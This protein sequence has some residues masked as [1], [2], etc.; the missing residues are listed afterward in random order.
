[1][2]IRC[3]SLSIQIVIILYNIVFEGD[4]VYHF[5]NGLYSELEYNSTILGHQNSSIDFWNVTQIDYYRRL[6]TENIEANYLTKQDS[7]TKKMVNITVD[8]FLEYDM[9]QR[10]GWTPMLTN[11]TSNSTTLYKSS[12]TTGARGPK[13]FDS[14]AAI[15]Y[16]LFDPADV[17]DEF[18]I[19]FEEND[20]L[21]EEGERC[22]HLT[23]PDVDKR[24]LIKDCC[25]TKPPN[26][27]NLASEEDVKTMSSRDSGFFFAQWGSEL[28]LKNEWSVQIRDWIYEKVRK[29]M[30]VVDCVGR[31]Y[32]FR[33]LIQFV[34]IEK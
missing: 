34:F 26:G 23:M 11:E 9:S 27:S 20:P 7:I 14:E 5:Q 30:C 16:F 22:H 4:G 15:F 19:K 10:E 25:F 6:Y 33:N 29:G 28:F 21:L 17:R 18:K 32:I 31:Q 3:T 1:M 12:Q 13:N 2:H 8:T 24:F